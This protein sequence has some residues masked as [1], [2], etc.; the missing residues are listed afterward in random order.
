MISVSH[1]LK[2]LNNLSDKSALQQHI[3]YWQ[4]KDGFVGFR[5]LEPSSYRK[6][7][8]LLTYW[9]SKKHYRMAS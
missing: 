4:E 2:S 7:Y 8:I 5:L 1:K 6:S 9:Q 3:A